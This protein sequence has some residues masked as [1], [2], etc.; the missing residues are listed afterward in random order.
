MAGGGGPSSTVPKRVEPNPQPR[1]RK[2]L[3]R[4]GDPWY[5]DTSE[6][7]EDGD[8]SEGEGLYLLSPSAFSPNETAE[9]EEGAEDKEGAEDEEGKTSDGPVFVSLGFVT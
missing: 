4:Q 6:G 8:E 2:I 3:P 9:G 7:E 5:A 1:R